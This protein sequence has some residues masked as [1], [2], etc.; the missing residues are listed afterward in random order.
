MSINTM[1]EQ[2][3]RIEEAE[4]QRQ[5]EK[6]S[7]I[8]KIKAAEEIEQFRSEVKQI[9]SRAKELGFSFRDITGYLQES[10]PEEKPTAESPKTK[11]PNAAKRAP[12]SYMIWLN[13]NRESIK[14]DLETELGR[15]L[16][17]REMISLI[18]KRAGKI[19]NEMSID[20]KKPFI[21]KAAESQSAY[22]AS[23]KSKTKPK[24]D[25]VSLPA[26]IAP[27]GWSGP[28]AGKSLLRYTCLGS[29]RGVGKF[30]T[31]EEAV[32]Q[33]EKIRQNGVPVGGITRDSRGYGIR[34]SSNLFESEN[35]TDE[36]S[37]IFN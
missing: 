36:V 1:R 12:S 30:N 17:G 5:N 23:T 34:L 29:K 31:F 13:E 18:G 32:A 22:K 27:E 4:R 6:E 25:F 35:T 9:A 33:V 19:W 7:L 16:K 37:W 26:E 15:K 20:A 8:A 3:E 28:F 14:N 21:E 10:F 2:L 24:I 11:D